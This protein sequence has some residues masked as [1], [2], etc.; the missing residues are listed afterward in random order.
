[1][2]EHVLGNNNGF[3]F[4]NRNMDMESNLK[5][6]QRYRFLARI[7]SD[8][9]AAHS[10]I[11]FT[12]GHSF[13]TFKGIWTL[14]RLI[15]RLSCCTS[16]SRADSSSFVFWRR[17]EEQMGT[18]CYCLGEGPSW[19]VAECVS[20]FVCVCWVHMDARQLDRSTRTT[21]AHPGS[22]A[23]FLTLSRSRSLYL[24]SPF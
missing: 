2:W 3:L 18:C 14:S 21:P 20:V 1:M 9:A 22:L 10:P 13:T 7:S 23:R 12:H 19:T 24:R 17:C 6:R 16:R 11:L 8:G 15:N 5:Y 4:W